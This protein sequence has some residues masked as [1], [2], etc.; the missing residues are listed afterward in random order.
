MFLVKLKKLPKKK[1]FALQKRISGL[2]QSFF[3]IF[4]VWQKPLTLGNANSHKCGCRCSRLWGF[5]GK[6]P[7][8]G[9]DGRP[10]SGLKSGGF[11]PPFVFAL[12]F[13][14]FSRLFF[15][16]VAIYSDKHACRNAF[17]KLN[18]CYR[19]MSYFWGTGREPPNKG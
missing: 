17:L 12:F 2:T 19:Q 3:L 11:F 18:F 8:R 14:R 10:R 5:R 15:R 1:S 6:A 7:R 16:V 9:G 13:R 4:G